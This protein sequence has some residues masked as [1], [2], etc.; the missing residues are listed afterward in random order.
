[1]NKTDLIEKIYAR[2]CLEYKKKHI[3]KIVSDVFDEMT[4]SLSDEG[5]IEFRGFGAFQVKSYNAF[6]S[7]NPKSGRRFVTAPSK[8]VKFKPSSIVK[9]ILIKD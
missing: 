6:N 9:K 5:R 2:E 3:E 8:R 1:M 7:R 4:G